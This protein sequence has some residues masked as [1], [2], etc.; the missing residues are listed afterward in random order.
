MEF[1]EKKRHKI[2]LLEQEKKN[3]EMEECT[4]KPMTYSRPGQKR[5]LQEF[6]EDQRRHEEEKQLKKN[7]ILEEESKQEG[8]EVHHPQ[9]CPG[10]A[11]LLAKKQHDDNV[12][13]YDRLYG[14]SK[15]KRIAN[16][17]NETPTSNI[18]LLQNEEEGKQNTFAPQINMKSKMIVRD[19]PVQD[20][21]YDDAM[22]RNDMAKIRVNK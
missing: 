2:E 11:K 8:R 17:L 3:K 9:I 13:V 19:R 1:Q 5:N 15:D 21:L 10:T 18:S 20:L 16:I 7:M 22:R 14:I 12:P 6:L 4:F